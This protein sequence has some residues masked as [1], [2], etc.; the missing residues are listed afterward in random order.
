MKI[1]SDKVKFKIALIKNDNDKSC[2]VCFINRSNLLFFSSESS[3]LSIK[4][5]SN[6]VGFIN[7]VLKKGLVDQLE[8]K[9]KKPISNGNA[10][11]FT[12]NQ[13]PP[14]ASI[15]NVPETKTFDKPRR[16][17]KLA[18]R[19]S[20]KDFAAKNNGNDKAKITEYFGSTPNLWALFKIRTGMTMLN[21]ILRKLSF[22][23]ISVRYHFVGV[24]P[25]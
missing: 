22:F 20:Y 15:V 7:K 3:L 2:V 13:I 18:L 17:M 11:S 25:S 4:A 14:K 8:I 6:V 5:I 19:V 16:A 9:T 1:L 23:C 10:A 21:K 24:L 12:A